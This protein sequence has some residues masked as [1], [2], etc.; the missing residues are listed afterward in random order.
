ME[1]DGPENQTSLLESTYKKKSVQRGKGGIIK[2]F[3]RQSKFAIQQYWHKMLLLCVNGSYSITYLTQSLRNIQRQSM[4]A[5]TPS[6][7]PSC[8][9]SQGISSANRQVTVPGPIDLEKQSTNA[10]LHRANCLPSSL[11]GKYFSSTA[12]LIYKVRTSN[13][14]KYIFV[15][16][17]L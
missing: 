6:L 7:L 10:C 9:C 1:T 12:A 5:F 15:Q 16:V 17:C 3:G 8:C 2:K 4:A 14:H 11:V 13:Y